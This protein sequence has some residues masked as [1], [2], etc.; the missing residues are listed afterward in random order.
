MSVIDWNAVALVT[1]V[2]VPPVQ[3]GG[4]AQ[5]GESFRL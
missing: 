1:Q 4:L 2:L 3:G 5:S